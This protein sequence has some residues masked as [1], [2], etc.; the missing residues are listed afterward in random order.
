MPG[1]VR[2][3]TDERDALLAYLGQQRYAL[4]VVCHG[5]T[6]EQARATPTASPLSVG[7]LVKHLVRGERAWV[8][9]LV[10]EDPP[11]VDIGTLAQA[12]AQEFQLGAGET[13]A[14]VLED[15]TR[16]GV[17]TEA[18]VRGLPGLDVPVPVPQGVPW[19][20]ADVPAWSARWV[21]LHLVEETARHA[22]HAD[23][24]R[25]SLDGA[26][27]FPLLAAVESWPASPFVRAWV[28]QPA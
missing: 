20:P 21:L 15:Y 3:V 5:L 6:E 26:T 1:L 14:G 25:E 9:R 2:P 27:T 19:F 24:L 12:Y 8:R 22:G 11:V 23:I 7:G 17:E 10:R 16:V 13:L 28:P 18:T 4:R